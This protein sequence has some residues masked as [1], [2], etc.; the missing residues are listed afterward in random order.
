MQSPPGR[1]ALRN[2]VLGLLRRAGQRNSAAAL[3]HYDWPSAA[4]LPS[5]VQQTVL[6]AE[7]GRTA[8]GCNTLLQP[9]HFPQ[10]M[11][12]LAGFLRDLRA[13][14]ANPGVGN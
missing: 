12:L 9:H 8:A 7:T 4:A 14:M 11:K 1:A 5:R 2:R 3:R 10:L 6:S 13:G